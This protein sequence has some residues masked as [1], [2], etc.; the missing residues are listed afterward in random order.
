MNANRC[1]KRRLLRIANN[2]VSVITL[3]FFSA[4][5][6]Y[7]LPAGQ[8][9]VNGQAAFNTQGGNLTIT[10]SPNAIINWQGFSINTN[11]AV[12][13]V[14]QSSAS[15]VLNRVVG[16]DPSRILGLLQSN[17]RVFLINPNGIL[18][19]QG[20][21]ID[22]NG[23]VA[24]TLNISNQDFLAGKY[25]FTA[26]AA[27]GSIQNQGTIT[28]PEGGS[29]YLIAPDIDNSG[30]IN[31]P[32]GDVILAAGHSVNLVDSVHPDIAVVVS[33]PE[34]TAVN[35]GEIL[36]QSGKVGIYGGLIS[37][38]GLVNAD[39]AVV[40]ENGR[41][42]LKA[43]K[44]IT[45]DAGST[46]SARGG[47]IE[48]LGGMES[49]TVR[50]SGAL[51]A[52][53]PNGGDGGFI[54]TSAAHV[55]VD[56]SARITTLAPYGKAGLWL[57]DPTDY[58]IAAV[59]PLNG[60]SYMSNTTLSTN[61]A[62]GSIVIQ[63]LAGGGGNGDIFVN[64]AVTWAN[65]NT[66]TLSAH[67]NININQNITNTGG[68]KLVLRADSDANGVGTVID[69]ILG[70]VSIA[71]GGAA[72]IFYNPPL[73]YN[74]PVLYGS[75]F[76][77]V[78]PTAYM[79]VNDVTQ[80]QN[81]LNNLAG[82][83]ALGK[84]IDATITNTWNAGA[85]FVPLGNDTLIPAQ[86][87]TGIFDGQGHT[88]TG[89]F[90]NRPTTNYV[91][92]FGGTIGG[93]TNIIRNVGLVNMNITGGF[94]TGGLVAHTGASVENCYTTGLVKSGS[95]N[96]GGL[97]GLSA[98]SVSNSYST[99]TVNGSG[100]SWVGGL[101]GT[102]YTGGSITNSYST[103][104]VSGTSSVGGLV[105]YNF[106]VGPIVSS[107]WDTQT[108]GRATSD[109]GTGKTT[110]EMKQQATFAGWD[111]GTTWAVAGSYPYLQALGSPPTPTPPAPTSIAAPGVTGNT[112]AID[113]TV[114]ALEAAT[115]AVTLETVDEEGSSDDQK[116]D[117]AQQSDKK[118]KD[119][120]E[121]KT[122][123]KTRGDKGKNF[124]N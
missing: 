114:V 76:P 5:A 36:A 61:L 108:S 52:S 109:G 68:G 33:A 123:E 22:V 73:G 107:Y 67:N 69:P 72:S 63:T 121:Q 106:G 74:F 53:A 98:G 97:V 47:T 41:I 38:R 116:S 78:Q 75:S 70:T 122:Y 83:Y 99:A 15:A 35:L 120:G 118:D 45:L 29:V 19:G 66:L 56:D 84:D 77:T 110:S 113:N 62:G 85:G 115:G 82:V 103:G 49:G 13:F 8:Q 92:M 39:S 93:P 119:S 17:G 30:I 3:I 65:S 6:V 88:I 91:G 32:R 46:T 104:P 14:Q 40:G 64:G 9:V 43:S 86:S 101:V 100:S 10:N 90:I 26:G 51:D 4:G 44:N 81:I 16:Q 105:G 18:F 11:E 2:L 95:N 34:N 112:V 58:T 1:R 57:I 60:S 23:L 20:A 80:L 117:E 50:V 102:L 31:S 124:C 12:R 89:L 55:K 21:R 71:A 87:F 59:D 42:L 7:A 54:E 24:S 27:A 28:T 111:F 94:Q 37:Q 79:L 25:N 96:V 48:V